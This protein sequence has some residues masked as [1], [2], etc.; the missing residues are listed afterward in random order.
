MLWL[1][2][3]RALVALLPTPFDLARMPVC[4]ITDLALASITPPKTAAFSS[5]TEKDMPKPKFAQS[6]E[7]EPWFKNFQLPELWAWPP[8]LPPCRSGRLPTTASRSG[9]RPY[10]KKA[11]NDLA[12]ALLAK[13]GYPALLYAGHSY[14]SGGATNLWESRRCRPLTIKLHGRWRSDCY[15]FALHP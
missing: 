7:N 6:R 8:R 4:F 1:T 12:R 15:F 3:M 5:I 14:R 9:T 2:A 11:F 13:A 10:S